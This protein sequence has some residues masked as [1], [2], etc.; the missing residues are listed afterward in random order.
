MKKFFRAGKRRLMAIRRAIRGKYDAAQTT[1]DNKKHWANADALSA[2]AANSFAVRRTLRMRARYE[3]ANNCYAR[4]IISTLANDA[5][6]R[7]P[8]LQLLTESGD[9]NTHVEKS[10]SDWAAEIRL[11]QKLRTARM[12]MASDGEAFLLLSNNPKLHHPVKLDLVLI[13]AD[14]VTTPLFAPEKGAKAVDGIVFDQNG[15]PVEYHVLKQH[16]GDTGWLGSGLE[17]DPVPASRV[18]HLFR[19][20]RP[21]Q[22]RGIPEI[23]PALPLFSQLRRFTLATLDAAETAANFSGVIESNG[24]AEEETTE[25]SAPF[26]EIELARNLFTTLPYGYKLGQMRA[27]H[28][29]TTYAM[30]KR[31][32]LNEMARCFN[33]PYNIAACNSSDYNYASGRLDHQTYDRAISVDRSDIEIV[34][35]D[36]IAAA[37]MAEAVLIE[38]LLPQSWR[39]MGATLPPRH[40]WFWT[41]RP[42]VDPSKEANAQETRLRNNS[43]TLAH[44]YALMGKDWEQELRQRAREIAL[45][46]ELGIEATKQTR[47]PARNRAD[48]SE[49]D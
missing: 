31:E 11:A 9:D 26:E 13:E 20:D 22:H 30:F 23:T 46:R 15:N 3:L 12:A 27:E 39:L 19:K 6:G 21:E 29:E 18:I 49:E 48:N 40:A 36:P 4:G 44:E 16:P 35:L 24:A 33:M 34:A 5:I 14:R 37:W 45:E 10:F 38:K 1:A 7:G 28:P 47:N 17:Y 41:N 43:T 2:D 25:E 42:H 32:L 8:R